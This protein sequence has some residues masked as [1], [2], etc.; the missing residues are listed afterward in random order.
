MTRGILITGFWISAVALLTGS[1]RAAEPGSTLS[2][3]EAIETAVQN[4]PIISAARSGVEAADARITQARSG[5]LPQLNFREYASR[6]DN[7]MWAFGTKLNQGMITQK[8][9]D[10]DRLN[11]PD[12]INNF[13]STFSTTWPLFDSGQTLYGWRQ[14][15]LNQKASEQMLQ[16]TRQVVICQAIVS[17]VGLLL[18]QE[19]LTVVQQTLETAHADL[20]MVQS[21]YAS[22]FVVKSDLLQAQVHIADLEQQHLEAD[23]Q[24]E[25][26]RADLNAAMGLPI[27]R[28]F[29]LVSALATGDEINGSLEQWEDTALLQRADLKQL[30]FHESIAQEEISKSRAAYLPSFNLVGN[31]EVNTENFSDSADN[32]TIGATINFNLFSGQH[33]SARVREA[34][35]G[36]RQATAQIEDLKAQIRVQTRRAFL[37]SR[38]AWQRI[39][40]ARAAVTQAEE[41]LRIVGNRYRNGLMTIVDLL[42]AELALQAARTNHLRAIHDYQAAKARLVLAA[43]T[44]D[45]NF[46]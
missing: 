13:A 28:R 11:N 31:Y 3:H 8:D 33:D 41:A 34:R 29:T 39:Q 24:V 38:S 36:L 32:Y 7:P 2:L 21:R 18:A 12:A 46:R 6:T 14:S 19:N 40:V 23:S 43:G 27:D 17:Y 35:A 42:N 5:F 15:L 25:V 20:K 1:V 16:R 37:Q 44:L 10:P 26:A 4:H 9:F 22:G 30:Q 45:E